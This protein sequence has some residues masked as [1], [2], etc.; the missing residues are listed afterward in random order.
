MR[1][2]G[3]CT[4]LFRDAIRRTFGKVLHIAV[5]FF[6][7]ISIILIKSGCLDLNTT[8]CKKERFARSS[9]PLHF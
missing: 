8:S 1:I 3:R 6:A 5:D 9:T 7:S 4:L 2:L